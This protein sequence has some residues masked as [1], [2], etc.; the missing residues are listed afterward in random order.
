MRA[1]R[2]GREV[3]DIQRPASKARDTVPLT[4]RSAYY[5][6]IYYSHCDMA[7]TIEYISYKISDFGTNIVSADEI[8]ETFRSTCIGE[9][10][11]LRRAALRAHLF[12]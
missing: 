1:N 7:T 10:A 2:R 11:T 6:F 12:W 8:E 4:Y 9:P 3:H 5:T